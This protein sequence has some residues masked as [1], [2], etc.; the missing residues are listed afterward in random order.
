LGGMGLCAC[1][2]LIESCAPVIGA[3]VL[4]DSAMESI[5]GN[6]L[7]KSTGQIYWSILLV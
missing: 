5:G 4:T 3:R 1:A 2:L 7:V 6:L